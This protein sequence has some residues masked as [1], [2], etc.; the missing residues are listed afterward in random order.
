M[1]CN[2]NILFKIFA[3]NAI[4]V[5]K[6]VFALFATFSKANHLAEALNFVLVQSTRLSSLVSKKGIVQYLSCHN[7][8]TI[9]ELYYRKYRLFEFKAG[10]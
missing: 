4:S 6:S 3:L 9:I 7:W 5:I 1:N 8:L 2:I 10:S